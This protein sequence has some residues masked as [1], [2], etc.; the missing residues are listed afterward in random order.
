MFARVLAVLLVL[1]LVGQAVAAPD[2]AAPA[3]TAQL[4]VG[5]EPFLVEVRSPLVDL[6]RER[7]V[8]A[9][10]AVGEPPHRLHVSS[11]F[12]PPR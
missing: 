9:P 3:E 7:F 11:V 6:P 12:R 8:V 5:D 2:V 1:G 4:D 10:P